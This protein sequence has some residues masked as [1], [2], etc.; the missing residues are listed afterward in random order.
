MPFLPHEFKMFWYLNFQMKGRNFERVEKVS[1][2]FNEYQIY[3]LIFFFEI[4]SIIMLL[5]CCGIYG[6]KPLFKNLFIILIFSYDFLFHYKN[7]V[8][9]KTFKVVSVFYIGI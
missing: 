4:P 7:V 9:K 1:N 8:N 2:I 6:N 5:T 3:I